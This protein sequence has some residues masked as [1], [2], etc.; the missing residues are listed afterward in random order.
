MLRGW[1]IRQWAVGTGGVVLAAMLIGIPTGIIA[2]PF[3]HRM[4]P[5]TWW[6]Y[7]AWA[8]TAALEGALLA[9]YV[10][11]GAAARASTR[12]ATTGGVLSFLAVGC[13][14]CNKLVVFAVGVSGACSTGRPCSPSWPPLR[15]LCWDSRYTGGC[16]A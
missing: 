1:T 9:T 11:T 16:A 5:V 3:Y 8:V 2:T 13:P 7:P 4:T 15:P 10:R 12:Q 6:S 14:V